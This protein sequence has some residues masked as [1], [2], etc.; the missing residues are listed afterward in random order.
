MIIYLKDFMILIE[1][2]S[3]AGDKGGAVFKR[4]AD[5][6]G[7]VSSRPPVYGGS[8]VIATNFGTSKYRDRSWC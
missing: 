2:H 1:I 6:Q 3:C 5:F 7:K 8:C 4:L